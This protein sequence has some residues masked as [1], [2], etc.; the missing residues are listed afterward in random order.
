M[1]IAALWEDA[2]GHLGKILNPDIFSLWIAVITP[3]EMKD[4]TLFL[5]VENDFTQTWLENN[6]RQLIMNALVLAGAPEGLKVKFTVRPSQNAD[7]QPEEAPA[8]PR[9]KKP[10]RA[11]GIAE[12][13]LN[14]RFTFKEYV[15]GETNKF[16]HAAAVAVAKT[17]GKAYNPLF[18]HGQSGIGKTHL[19]Q[20]VGNSV[21]ETMPEARVVYISTEALLNEFI[22]AIQNKSTLE[23]RRRYRNVDVLLVDDVHFLGSK[24][25]LQEEFF[26]TFNALHGAHK[27]IIITSDRP[28]RE[29]KGLEQRIVSRL[30]WGMVTELEKP[31]FE[32]RLAML[33]LKQQS[34]EIKLGD[35]TLD[36]IA[37]NVQSNVRSLEGAMRKAMS[38]VALYKDK[39]PGEEKLRAILKDFLDEELQQEL[40][41]EII[42]RS[43]GEYFDVRLADMSSKRR[44][45]SVAL[46][47]QIAMYL[48]RKLTRASLQDIAD[49]FGKTHA[50]VLH[51]IKAIQNRIDTEDKMRND[52]RQI[53]R[54]LGRDP[55]LCQL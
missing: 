20:A 35:G 48:A 45:R 36:F 15:V 2:R 8:E 42:Q 6:Y 28:A 23:F 41:F 24:Q 54:R 22:D 25:Q 11:R 30:E 18:I 53:I 16:T 55:N 33:K 34:E 13:P 37:R 7:P 1:E 12:M 17:P 26:N 38:Y 40:S 31:D 10:R 4:G 19:M 27:Q 29:I 52:V 9:A 49:A 50:T 43:V 5:S 21:R 39:A 46:P 3:L 14:D 47:R 32:T 44:P 51:G